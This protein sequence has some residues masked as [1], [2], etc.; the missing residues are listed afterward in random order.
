MSCCVC[1]HYVDGLMLYVCL[2]QMQRPPYM[3]KSE[4]HKR[5]R[6]QKS[7]QVPAASCTVT[8]QEG[9]QPSVQLALPLE[10][11]GSEG[12]PPPPSQAANAAEAMDLRAPS[13]ALSKSRQSPPPPSMS[14]PAAAKSP[15]PPARSPYS[16][17]CNGGED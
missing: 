3:A 8:R 5:R 6:K 2:P 9:A 17:D 1:D 7:P 14:P 4:I 16:P 10:S 11:D 12:S 15:P 13:P